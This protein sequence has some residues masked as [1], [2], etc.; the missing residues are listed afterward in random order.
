MY[1]YSLIV[2]IGNPEHVNAMAERELT[3]RFGDD[4][5][6]Q[7]HAILTDESVII[8][9]GESKSHLQRVL[10]D[11]FAEDIGRTGSFRVG[12]LLHYRQLVSGERVG[13]DG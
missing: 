6:Y 3:A 5:I 4:V 9:Y 1:R 7:T 11:W 2:K 13:L 12:T 10:D 8:V